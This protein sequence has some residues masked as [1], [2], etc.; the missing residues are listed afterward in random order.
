M[1]NNTFSD[2]KVTKFTLHD[3]TFFKKN[4]NFTIYLISINSAKI[5]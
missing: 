1:T 4:A 3:Q 2:N 5:A